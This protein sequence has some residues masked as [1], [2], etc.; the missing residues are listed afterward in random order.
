ML[1]LA[2]AASAATLAVQANDGLDLAARSK[3]SAAS[4]SVR[5]VSASTSAPFTVGASDASVEAMLRA[6]AQGPDLRSACD[7]AKLD[8]CYD[9]V[10]GRIVYKPAREYMPRFE[11]LKAES[12]SLRHDRVV[13]K[14]TFK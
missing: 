11:G 7:R 14:Y 12:V 2:L 10:D 4:F 8:V 6:E 3:M 13:F 5:S 1:M 9:A